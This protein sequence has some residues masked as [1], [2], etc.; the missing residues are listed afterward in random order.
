[1]K[2]GLD[3]L[4]ARVA[5]GRHD[6]RPLA[7]TLFERNGSADEPWQGEHAIEVLAEAPAP[8]HVSRP[9]SAVAGARPAPA[10]ATAAP[11]PTLQVMHEEA[12]PPPTTGASAS[13]T[14]AAPGAVSAE[15]PPPRSRRE[16]GDSRALDEVAITRPD[17]AA[18]P[19]PS[20]SRVAV[21]PVAAPPFR[22]DQQV[23]VETVEH[24]SIVIEIGRI[25]VKVPAVA[26]SQAP[27]QAPMQR[28]GPRLTLDAYLSERR[29]ARR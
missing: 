15:S 12:A 23:L 8:G 19:S 26:P 1:M 11:P 25:E 27:A 10:A 6:V 18:A 21:P 14:T 16:R 29:E 9:S 28:R 3:R 24:N 22:P 2:G 7:P 13:P 17:P 20:P 4:I 5:L